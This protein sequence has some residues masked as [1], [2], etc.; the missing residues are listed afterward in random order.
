[1]FRL[2]KCPHCGTI[3]RYKDVK[4][5]L[6]KKDNTC[7]HCEKKFRAKIFP[8]IIAGAGL[9]IILAILINILLMTRMENLELI[10]LFIVTVLF[11]LLVFLILPYFTKFQKTE[12]NSNINEKQK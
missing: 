1:M 9:P 7:Y 11:I 8:G 10:P 5:A 6:R 3:Y 2:P 4:E 12:E